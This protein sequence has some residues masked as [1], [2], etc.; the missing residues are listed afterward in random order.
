MGARLA[1]AALD[2]AAVVGLDGNPTRVLVRMA[3]SALDDAAA[4]VYF[5]GWEPLALALGRIV[6][7][8]SDDPAA[9]RARRQAEEAVRLAMK[10]LVAGRLV[11]VERRGAPGRNARYSLTLGP[12]DNSVTPPTEPGV[13]REPTPLAQRG[14][15]PGSAR[16]T[17]LIEPGAEEQEENK[18]EERASARPAA[19]CSRHAH[20]ADPPNCRACMVAR[21][22][23]EAYDAAEAEREADARRARAAALTDPSAHAEVIE[24]TRQRLGGSTAAVVAAALRASPDSLPVGLRLI[25]ADDVERWD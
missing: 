14:N 9:I 13:S 16:P 18:E 19:R 15:T 11:S 6:P 7:P 3:L 21:L 17:P 10:P 22:A 5:G 1:L 12:V 24:A 2:A 25:T 20:D 4:P 23:A 8:P